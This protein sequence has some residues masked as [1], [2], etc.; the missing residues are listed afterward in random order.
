MTAVKK[1]SGPATVGTGYPSSSRMVRSASSGC[2]ANAERKKDHTDGDIVTGRWT[3]GISP[4]DTMEKKN[5]SIRDPNNHLAL[6]DE[7]PVDR[8]PYFCYF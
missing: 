7:E 4:I 2:A 6:P 5:P 3:E 8:I 1:F